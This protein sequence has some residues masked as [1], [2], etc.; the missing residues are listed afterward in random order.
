MK[1]NFA[2]ARPYAFTVDISTVVYHRSCIPYH[3]YLTLIKHLL[4]YLRL[5]NFRR[6]RLLQDFVLTEGEEAF[7]DILA[8]READEN[9]LPWEEWA[10]EETRE[11]LTRNH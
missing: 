7:Q 4:R 6:L 1:P 3:T 2:F 9:R 10:V 5:E 8:E 11:L